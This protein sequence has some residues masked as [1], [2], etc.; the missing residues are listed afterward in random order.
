MSSTV[1]TYDLTGQS[2][3]PVNFEYLARRFVVITLVGATKRRLTLNVDYRFTA[4]N[5]IT[6]TVPQN[7]GEFTQLEVRRRT[8]ATDRLVNF[9]DGSILRSQDLNISQ[10]QS[11]HIAEEGRDVADSSLVNNGSYWNALGFPMKNLGYGTEPTDAATMQNVSDEM[12][13]TL[14]GAQGET[15]KE[16]PVPSLRTNRLMAFDSVGQPTTL[17]ATSGSPQEL[18]L[19]LLD[20]TN[21][22]K[23][24]A[25]VGR[26]TRHAVEISE[27]RLMEGRYAGDTVIVASYYGG[28]AA[29]TVATPMGGGTFVWSEL[30]TRPDNA[31]S[32]IRL[33]GKAGAWVRHGYVLKDVDFGVQGNGYNET[34]LMQRLFD[35]TSDGSSVELTTR[36]RALGLK[37]NSNSIAFSARSSAYAESP[38][39]IPLLP[40]TIPVLEVGGYGWEL[41]SIRVDDENQEYGAVFAGSVGIRFKRADGA[42]DVDAYLRGC[43]V[44]RFDVGVQIVGIN[45]SFSELCT[46]SHCRDS[47]QVLQV[48]SETVRGIRVIGAR[49][50][51]TPDTLGFCIRI[52]GTA[53]QETEVSGCMADGIGGFYSGQLGRRTLLRDNAVA[54]PKATAYVI[55]GGT[56]GTLSGGSIG[57]GAGSAIVA[58]DTLGCVFSGVTI[59]SMF[60]NGLVLSGSA[61]V[62]S[63]DN[64]ILGMNITNVNLV[65]ASPVGHVYDGIFVGENC[66]LTE[67]SGNSVRQITGTFGRY[68]ICNLGNQTVV[69]APNVV[70]GFMTAQWFQSP[71]QRVYGDISV[72]PNRP[73]ITRSTGRA[74]AGKY[75]IGDIHE[76]TAPTATLPIV[77]WV[78]TAASPVEWRAVEWVPQQFPT[79]PTLLLSDLGVYGIYNNKPVMWNGTAWTHFDGTAIV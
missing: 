70:S 21:L 5:E 58:T 19:D 27:L 68:G 36:V 28:W 1:Y 18:E 52:N 50:H 59:D 54:T 45:T 66:V 42:R 38:C 46:F 35:S 8:S 22:N 12:R 57:G 23:G 53:Q 61:S 75:G 7:P 56:G 6:T 37:C 34:L 3:F 4:K 63:R 49:F 26:A 77:K 47:I 62:S 2:V 20:H 10:I 79:L 73:R 71:D 55:T 60:Q 67:I 31:G 65:Y 74:P 29:M 16:I 51:G 30:E 17:T 13:R 69:K 64:K 25:R 48:G 44:A 15:L 9:T 39:L 11:I 78:C 72:N 43:T 33:P 24:A 76:N 32:V 14:R 41:D 40:S